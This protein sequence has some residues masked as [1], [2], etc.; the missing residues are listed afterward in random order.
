MSD[1]REDVTLVFGRTRAFGAGLWVFVAL[2]SL[3]LMLLEQDA[4][5][6]TAL[7]WTAWLLLTLACALVFLPLGREVRATHAAIAAAVIGA[8]GLV[9][10]GN[11]P[12][13]ASGFAPWYV[14]YGTIVVVVLILRSRPLA[15]WVGA[16]AMCGTLLLWAVTA[17]ESLGGWI[18]VVLRQLATVAAFQVFAVI[19]ARATARIREYRAEERERLIREQR[20]E[21]VAREHEAGLAR[22]LV[23]ADPV[24]SRLAEGVDDV[25]L[26]REATLAEAGV[27]D[28]LRGR[29]LAQPPLTEAVRSARERGT[30]VALLDDLGDADPAPSAA[31]LAWAAERVDAARGGV[32]TVRIS[33]GDAGSR[34]TVADGEGS[35]D[36]FDG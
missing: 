25:G 17:G 6:P 2:G 10:L 1:M 35:F 13:E 4:A 11:P 23:L 18:A 31:M 5:P 19:L 26:A 24:L 8:M 14:R 28:L 12:S 29:R 3:A 34:L 20:R 27:R 36:A 32:V 7:A 21:V 33:G 16:A 15:G 30:A 9:P 22:I